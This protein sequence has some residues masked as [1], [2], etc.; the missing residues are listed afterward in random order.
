MLY[1]STG[2]DFNVL[3]DTGS[4]PLHEAYPIV[5]KSIVELILS[6][7]SKS[8]LSNLLECKTNHGETL[9]Y[10]SALRG[11]F[12][13]AERILDINESTKSL[14]NADGNTPLHAAVTTKSDR[15]VELLIT[16]Y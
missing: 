4:T 15:L 2:I 11:F 1:P 8:C 12:D 7:I 5:N 16:R 6:Y 14:A 3:N 10:F 13:I 9:L